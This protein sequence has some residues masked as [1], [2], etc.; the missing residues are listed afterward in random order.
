MKKKVNKVLPITFL[1]TFRKESFARRF[2]EYKKQIYLKLKLKINFHEITNKNICQ[3]INL[4]K[5]FQ[6]FV[7]RFL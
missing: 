4:R 1:Y 7:K 3:F 6:N 2:K 5:K